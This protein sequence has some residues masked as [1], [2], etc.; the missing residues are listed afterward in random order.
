MILWNIHSCSLIL[1]PEEAS[2]TSQGAHQI[3]SCNGTEQL[4]KFYHLTIFEWM[5]CL[6][7]VWYYIWWNSSIIIHMLLHLI[8]NC[9]KKIFSISSKLWFL[10]AV[11]KF[12]CFSLI[13]PPPS[14][15]IVLM[16]HAHKLFQ[17][18][19]LKQL[20]YWPWFWFVC[21]LR[22]IKSLSLISA[23]TSQSTLGSLLHLLTVPLLVLCRLYWSLSLWRHSEFSTPS[24]IKGP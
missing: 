8:R 13:L 9:P 4:S 11:S 21:L 14:N 10:L 3:T 22:S 18:L 7:L 15:N 5:K 16:Y 20:W 23:R 6:N 17:K 24:R 2:H 1:L 12:E 19:L